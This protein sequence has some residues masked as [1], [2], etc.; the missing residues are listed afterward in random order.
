MVGPLPGL[1]DK[2]QILVTIDLLALTGMLD[3]AGLTSTGEVL[4]AATVRRLAC[5]AGIIPAVLGSAGQVLDLGRTRRL[6]TPGQ[7]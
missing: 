2:A 1:G 6:F 7:R 5:E 3:R 4:S